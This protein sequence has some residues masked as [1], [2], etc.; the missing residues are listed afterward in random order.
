MATKTKPNKW[1][2]ALKIFNKGK[3]KYIVPKKGTK[4][5]KEVRKIMEKL[6]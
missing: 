4:E 2:R 3:P 5:Y 6:K 1:I